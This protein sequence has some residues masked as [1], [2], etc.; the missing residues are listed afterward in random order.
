MN[1]DSYLES[2]VYSA[3]P[4]ELVCLLYKKAIEKTGV[5]RTALAQGDIPARTAAIT[6]VVEIVGELAQSLV[7][8]PGS[9][10][11]TVEMMTNLRR[12]YEY[13]I[14]QLSTAQNEQTAAPL[15][16]VERVLQTLLEAWEQL[17]AGTASPPPDREPADHLKR[18]SLMFHG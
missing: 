18:P 13:L 2:R 10:R 12:L 4:A 14:F 6:R 1:Y 17:A 11:T 9:D 8:P 5:A 7:E 3:S 16:Q 15:D